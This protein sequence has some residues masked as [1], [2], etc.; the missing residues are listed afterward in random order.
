M[1]DSIQKQQMKRT[2]ANLPLSRSA[3]AAWVLL[4]HGDPAGSDGRDLTLSLKTAQSFGLTEINTILPDIAPANQYVL[5]P[6]E[7]GQRESHF[8]FSRDF[9]GVVAG[10]YAGHLAR[11]IEA[12][13]TNYRIPFETALGVA[14]K[15]AYDLHSQYPGLDRDKLAQAV[16]MDGS[17]RMLLGA[18]RHS[19]AYQNDLISGNVVNDD[20]RTLKCSPGAA[21]VVAVTN[22]S[23]GQNGYSLNLDAPSLSILHGEM[24]GMVSD[25]PLSPSLEFPLESASYTAIFLRERGEVVLNCQWATEDSQ[26]SGWSEKLMF[27]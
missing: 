21:P 26:A 8:R 7:S 24:S 3:R 25:C 10:S 4:K 6:E 9:I 17:F 11:L 18:L 14:L 15:A 5:V 20:I 1:N 13:I 2:W 23:G 27:K 22:S 19:D 16:I 12:N